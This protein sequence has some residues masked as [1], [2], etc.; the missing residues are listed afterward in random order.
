MSEQERAARFIYSSVTVD[1][2][3]H[4]LRTARIAPPS[5]WSVTVPT[6]P[7][8]AGL[9]GKRVAVHMPTPE[10]VRSGEAI[11]ISADPEEVV[12][13]GDG[14]FPLPGEDAGVWDPYRPISGPR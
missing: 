14:P 2:V 11:V 8:C 1:G 12:L 10:G 9:V 3:H 4:A 6:W 13:S 7:G 5:E